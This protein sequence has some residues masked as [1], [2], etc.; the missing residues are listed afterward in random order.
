MQFTNSKQKQ[1][2]KNYKRIPMTNAFPDVIDNVVH[3]NYSYTFINAKLSCIKNSKYY[4]KCF[5][6]R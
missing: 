6:V 1:V 3:F 4:A 5:Y 2:E